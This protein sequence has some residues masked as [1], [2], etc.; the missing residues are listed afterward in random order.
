MGSYF[1]HRGLGHLAVQCAKAMGML[2][3]AV[4]VQD[5]KLRLAQTVGADLVVNAATHDPVQEIQRQIGGAHG[6][7]VT[8]VSRAAFAQGVGMLRR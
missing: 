7:L 8:A 4:D 3:A 2:V 6:A 1:G 5:D